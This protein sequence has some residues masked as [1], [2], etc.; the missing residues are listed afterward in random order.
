[1]AIS[2]FEAEQ[3]KWRDLVGGFILAF[4]D[5]ELLTHRLW[6]DHCQG[7]APVL[8]RD[9]TSKLL[10]VLKRLEPRNDEVIDCLVEALRIATKRNTIAHNPMQAQVFQH[11][12]T[13]RVLVEMAISSAT[14]DD[15]I[16]DAELKEL[17]AKAEDLVTRLY[18]ALGFIS[19]EPR[20]G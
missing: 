10:S 6:R 17:R 1:V 2:E 14:S 19:R 20:V 15:Y 16:D 5:V 11:S 12:R 9:R 13:G 8:F 18:I 4:G 3:A 7:N